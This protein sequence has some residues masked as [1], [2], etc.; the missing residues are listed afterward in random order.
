[1]PFLRKNLGRPDEIRTFPNGQL[2]V[3]NLGDTVIGRSVY[4]PGWRW[5]DDVKP[6]IG[7]EWCEV[8]HQ[9]LVI[10]GRIR[11]Q[12]S[13]GP[14]LELG[15]GD[16][17][18]VPAGHDAWVVGDEP[19]ISLD[20]AG[21]RNFAVGSG[22]G[23]PGVLASILFTDIVNSTPVAAR[24]GNAGWRDLIAEH[25]QRAR[26][27]IDRFR[28]REV[29]TTGDGFLV[30]F[31]SPASALRCAAGIIAAAG[32]LGIQLRAGVHSGE[33]EMTGADVRGI[34]VHTAARVMSAAAPDEVLASRIAHD[35]AAGSGL[36][37]E[38]RGPHALKGLDEPTEL[39][40]LVTP[41]QSG[42]G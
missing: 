13:D 19:W 37:F 16:L 41:I 26:A 3:F 14:E 32:S 15:P 29:S 28:G 35:L 23:R 9:G 36:R 33:V 11:V 8:H 1:V 39:F 6:L 40:A 27:E 42:G 4:E 5:A 12:S 18:D 25:N 38:S 31:D 10:S 24:L 20:F 7:T 21:R 34:V 30:V 17:F 22:A 2:Q